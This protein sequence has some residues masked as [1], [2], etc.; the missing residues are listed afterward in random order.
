VFYLTYVSTATRPFSE[1]DLNELMARSYENNARLDLTGMLLYKEGNFMQVFERE[2]K[3]VRVLYEKISDDLR[4]K[5][6]VLLQQ[7][8]LEERQFPE[9]S[10]GFRDLDS[11]EVRAIPGYSEFLN[12]PLTGQEFSTEPARTTGIVTT[13]T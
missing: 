4:H 13:T 8:H 11:P 12:T 3:D 9:W 10:M 6:V 2:E 1:A 7:G 5:G